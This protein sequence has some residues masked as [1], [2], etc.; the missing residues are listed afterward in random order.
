MTEESEMM[1][2]ESSDEEGTEV[3]FEESD[4]EHETQ[5]DG[6]DGV[7]LLPRDADRSGQLLHLGRVPANHSHLW[8]WR[9]DD[10]HSRQCI[11][12][13]ANATQHA[14]DHR[15]CCRVHGSAGH[16]ERYDCSCPCLAS[17]DPTGYLQQTVAFI[18]H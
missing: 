13:R 16:Q 8:G 11:F 4:E 2:A 7:C 6:A 5:A 15:A 17:S 3:M 10:G 9:C 14:L 12:H 1:F 18:K